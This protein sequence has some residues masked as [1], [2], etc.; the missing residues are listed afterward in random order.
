MNLTEAEE[1]NSFD[2]RKRLWRLHVLTEQNTVSLTPG[3]F[4]HPGT[5]RPEAYDILTSPLFLSNDL[6]FLGI[7]PKGPYL[8]LEKEKYFFCVV[9]TYFA[10][11]VREIR[12]FHVAVKQRRLKS[13]QK[14]VTHVKSCCFT[15]INLLL[16]SSSLRHCRRRW[17]SSPLLWSRNIATMVTWRHTSPLY[18]L[19]PVFSGHLACYFGVACN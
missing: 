4:T 18:L 9:F 17:L 6:K 15:D 1:H 16:F 2:H 3:N 13:V 10:K 12:K 8:G 14:S 7:N 19:C 11:R 5:Q